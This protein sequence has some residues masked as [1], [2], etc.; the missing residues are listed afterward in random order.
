[1]AN[2]IDITD[3]SKIVLKALQEQV[4]KGLVSIGERAE[5]YAKADCPVATGR[6]QNSITHKIKDKT[7]YIGTNVEYAA[8]VEFRDVNHQSGKAHFLRDAGTTHGEEYSAKMKA[9][10]KALEE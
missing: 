9:A 7:I 6:L 8:P 10:L 1:M 4:F 2:K 3:N 5:F